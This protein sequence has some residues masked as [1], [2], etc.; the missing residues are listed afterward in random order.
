MT[1]LQET[2]AAIGLKV[3]GPHA[4]VSARRRTEFF[5]LLHTRAHAEDR[6]FC[7]VRQIFLAWEGV[8]LVILRY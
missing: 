8:S 1:S 2:P 5:M 3:V 4:V 7:G 6:Y